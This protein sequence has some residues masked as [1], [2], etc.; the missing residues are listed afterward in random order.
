MT[1]PL[2]FIFSFNK[3]H[4]IIPLKVKIIEKPHTVFLPNHNKKL[5]KNW[6]EHELFK[7]EVLSTP[8][9]SQL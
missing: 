5:P 2:E 6:P 8:A 9:I 7:T 4:V 3:K 1:V